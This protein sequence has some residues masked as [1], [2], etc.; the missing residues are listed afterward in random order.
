[1]RSS[2]S[3]A[4]MTC[5]LEERAYKASEHAYAP[6]SRFRVGAAIRAASGGVYTGCNVENASY[7][8]TMCAERNAIA[9]A[10]CAEGAQIIIEEV[11]V[12]SPDASSCSPCGA[13][14]QAIAELAPMAAIWFLHDNN[15]VQRSCD[16]LLPER[17]G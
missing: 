8:L 6:Y 16:E 9:A 14:R 15:L 10:V 5:E 3:T 17:F 7:G 4:E 1:M 13:C 11:I 12:V 2:V